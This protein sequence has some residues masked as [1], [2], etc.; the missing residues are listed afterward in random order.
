VRVRLAQSGELYHYP[1]F[2][3][4]RDGARFATDLRRNLSRPFGYEVRRVC[5]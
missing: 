2:T 5:V 4:N 1:A 3:V